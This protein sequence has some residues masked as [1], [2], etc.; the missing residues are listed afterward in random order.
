M[1]DSERRLLNI[2][3]VLAAVCAGAV[4][5]Q[6]LLR[7]QRALD[8]RDHAQGL[9]QMEA[10]AMMSEAGLWQARLDWLTTHQPAMTSENH[11]SQELLDEVLSSAAANRL[12]VQKKQLHEATRQPFFHE[13]GV[14]VSLV[15]DLPDVIRWM[16]ALQDPESFRLVSLFKVIPDGKDQTKISVTVRVNRRHAP[17]VVASPPAKKEGD[18]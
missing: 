5:S 2:L 15:G 13:V 16:F 11:A 12:A 9:Q 1:K 4:M 7:K 8:Q 6:G 17:A 14:T 18:S 10:S 3:G